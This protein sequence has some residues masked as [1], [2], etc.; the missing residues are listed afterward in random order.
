M[1]ALS[2]LGIVVPTIVAIFLGIIPY[3]KQKLVWRLLEKINK[4]YNLYGNLNPSVKNNNEEIVR[5]LYN[6]YI[7]AYGLP[8]FN[9]QNIDE[10]NKLN[11]LSIQNY[12]YFSALSNFKIFKYFHFWNLVFKKTRKILHVLNKYNYLVETD[13]GLVTYYDSFITKIKKTSITIC[14]SFDSLRLYGGVSWGAS[15]YIEN[16]VDLKRFLKNDKTRKNLIQEIKSSIFS[17]N[18]RF[19]VKEKYIEETKKEFCSYSIN[20]NK[21]GEVQSVETTFLQ[22][23]WSGEIDNFRDEHIKWIKEVFKLKD[24]FKLTRNK[25]MFSDF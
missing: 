5:N 24:N 17:L 12:S 7:F 1:M 6:Q 3:L 21:N 25:F 20:F 11:P 13:Y 10:I 2:I 18:V 14:P 4:F 19:I 23:E 9:W 8:K 22:S 16:K 15:D